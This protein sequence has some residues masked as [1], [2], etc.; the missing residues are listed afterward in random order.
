MNV[1]MATHLQNRFE[2]ALVAVCTKCM[3]IFATLMSFFKDVG[4]RSPIKL[5][6]LV[7]LLLTFPCFE[8]SQFFFKLV[9]LL[10]RRRIARLGG[11]DLF[12]ELKD[13]RIASDLVVHVLHRL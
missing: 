4:E 1:S 11:D 3:R 13:G 2:S 7:A 5:L 6:H 8:A 9:Y 10:N 12:P